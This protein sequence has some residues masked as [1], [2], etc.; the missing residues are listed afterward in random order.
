VQLPI[1]KFAQLATGTFL[2][3]LRQRLLAMIAIAVVPIVAVVLYQAKLRRDVQILEVHESAWRLTHVIAQRQSQLVDSVKQQLTLLAQLPEIDKENSPACGEL[4]RRVIA[5]K[6]AYFDVGVVN[7][8]GIVGCRARDSGPAFDLA[9]SAL[10]RR[11]FETKDFVIGDFQ[12]LGNWQRRA[13]MFG[14][15]LVDGSGAVRDILIA[16]LDAKRID[17]LAAETNLPDGMTLTVLD[18]N[19]T[20]LTRVPD[21]ETWTGKHMPDAPLL[22][23]QQL[24]N[25]PTKEIEG[26]DGVTRLYAF[27]TI[28]AGG[29][30]GQLHV[31][32]G[33]SSSLAYREANYALLTSLFW[34]TVIT[35]LA[36]GFAWFVGSKYV[37]EYLK[38]RAE[39]EEARGR[40]AAIVDSS[41]DGIIGMTLDGAITSWNGGA[42][43]MYGYDATTI[44]GQNVAV[45]TPPEHRGEIPELM[46][47][48]CLGKGV[49][50]YESERIC[51]DGRRIAVSA[52]LSPIRDSQGKVR[53]AATITRDITLLRKGEEQLL[54]HTRQLEALQSIAE[55]TAETLSLAEMVPHSLEKL[56]ALVPCDYAVAYFIHANGIVDSY[57]AAQPAEPKSQQGELANALSDI[58]TQCTGEWFIDD[59][60]LVPELTAMCSRHGIRSMAI[61]PMTRKDRC[62]TILGLLY[63]T[64]RSFELEETQYLKALARPIALG[65]EN[66]QLYE[67]SLALIDELADEIEERKK[68]EK[69]LADFNAM[70][71]H[72]LRSPLS[73]IVSMAESV[74]EEVFGAVNELQ[75]SWLGKIEINCR[76]LIDQVSDFLDVSRIDAGK[77]KLVGERVNL[78]SQIDELVAEHSIEAEKRKIRLITTIDEHLPTVW[79]DFRRITQV[80]TNFFSNALKFTD[81]GGTIEVSAFRSQG[82]VV[83]SVR[84]SGVGMDAEDQKYIF[85]MYSQVSSSEKSQKRGSGVGLVICKKIIEAHG[86]RIWV[87][88]GL[89]KGSCFYFSLPLQAEREEWLLTPA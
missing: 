43:Q 76:T 59:V 58:A 26:L 73:N 40:L 46:K 5:Q 44:L 18:R 63:T 8:A 33:V 4:L 69:Q 21:H 17:Q 27:N 64:S 13:L 80:L 79:A 29:E 28:G 78:E 81:R 88:S 49:N 10:R 9:H 67:S 61:L 42:E 36:S 15:P 19:G 39:A 24:R 20:I 51:Q 85:Q 65:V 82:A 34:I 30:R 56:V 6:Q 55:G 22:E 31:I 32:V 48:V 38:K 16:A 83:V 89:G 52:S 72:D 45:L 84:D 25:Q 62:R 87:E 50:R 37:L 77:L 47:F 75:R 3:K 7:A 53:G 54:L 2:G 23:L 14:Y 12:L 70:V 60:T 74:K 41:E 66:G 68:A 35:A 57:A 71:V 86:G 1:E 11:I